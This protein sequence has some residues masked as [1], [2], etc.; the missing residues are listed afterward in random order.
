MILLFGLSILI[1]LL[2]FA[3]KEGFY[4]D[5]NTYSAISSINELKRKVEGIKPMLV[6]IGNQEFGTM[7]IISKL[8]PI[9]NTYE[10]K[11]YTD[12]VVR[13]VSHIND[14]LS[15]LQNESVSIQEQL[16]QVQQFNRILVDYLE[17]LEEVKDLLSNI[18]DS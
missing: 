3:P 1:I 17:K 10:D 12:D 4:S 13:H 15:K 9:L 14:K 18:P 16:K 8:R 7:E 6:E 11:L 2:C 5:N